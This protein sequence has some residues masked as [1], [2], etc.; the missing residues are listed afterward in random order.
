MSR[1]RRTLSTLWSSSP[2]MRSTLIHSNPMRWALRTKSTHICAV[3]SRPHCSST[4]SSKDCTPLLKLGA[5]QLREQFQ[6][7]R[8]ER[9]GSPSK[10]IAVSG[11]K[12]K[13]SR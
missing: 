12:S 10:R 5:A 8:R 3:C 7:L 1:S 9:A 2:Y 4:G 13:F 6:L 11:V